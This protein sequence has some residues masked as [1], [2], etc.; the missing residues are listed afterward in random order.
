MITNP[1]MLSQRDCTFV[2]FVIKMILQ[3]LFLKKEKH[4]KTT[5]ITKNPWNFWSVNHHPT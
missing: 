3:V 1:D 2:C 5:T 4:V